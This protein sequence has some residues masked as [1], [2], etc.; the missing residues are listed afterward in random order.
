[1]NFMVRLNQKI[2]HTA[3]KRGIMAIGGLSALIPW[4]GQPQY[5]EKAIIWAKQEKFKD[6]SFGFD[7][8][9]VA[10][11]GLVKVGY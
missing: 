1:M 11:P 10:H 8:S 5:T 7:G 6:A 9:W 4:K 3:H 2:I